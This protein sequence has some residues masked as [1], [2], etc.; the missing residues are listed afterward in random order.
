M[1]IDD[2]TNEIFP[3]FKEI[4]I[5]I[6]SAISTTNWCDEFYGFLSSAP[7]PLNVSIHM[8]I[9]SAW[10]FMKKSMEESCSKHNIVIFIYALFDGIQEVLTYW[11][12]HG[13]ANASYSVR[14]L[15]RLELAQSPSWFAGVRVSKES[16]RWIEYQLKSTVLFHS[17]VYVVDGL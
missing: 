6:P 16:D 12:K 14:I 10:D 1:I 3:A 15:A 7:N 11:V 13:L 8:R 9:G 17:P 2:T 4:L 5:S